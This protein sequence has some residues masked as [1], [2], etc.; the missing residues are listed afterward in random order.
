MAVAVFAEG[1]D[2]AA[3]LR[4]GGRGAGLDGHDH[5]VAAGEDSREAGGVGIG[6]A[7]RIG[8]EEAVLVQGDAGIE[9]QR[10]AD[11]DDAGVVF[12]RQAQAVKG[13]DALRAERAALETGNDE[14]RGDVADAEFA[15]EQVVDLAGFAVRG[16][17]AGV[18][19]VDPDA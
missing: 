18:G 6:D 19:G 9:I 5:R 8:V 14:A 15:A 2:Q 3:G 11:A 7:G 12:E 17:H 10:A 4:G 13:V 1:V 16:E